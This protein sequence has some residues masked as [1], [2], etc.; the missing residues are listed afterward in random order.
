[1]RDFVRRRRFELMAAFALLIGVALLVDFSAL[2]S[3]IEASVLSLGRLP[4]NV[5]LGTGLIGVTLIVIAWQMRMRFLRSSFWR[6]TDCPRC[7]SPLHRVHR[8]WYERVLGKTLLPHSR[9]YRCS[10]NAC[11]WSGLRH[12]RRHE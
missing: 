12:S 7:Q 3:A 2:L 9:R 6:V 10:N 11:G 8:R 1:M 5:V 4:T